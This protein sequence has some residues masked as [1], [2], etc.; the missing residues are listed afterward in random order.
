MSKA[1]KAEPWTPARE[2]ELRKRL[3]TEA[4]GL[5]QMLAAMAAAPDMLAELAR[6]RGVLREIAD[7]VDGPAHGMAADAVRGWRP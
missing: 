6:L 5:G 7:A 1:T 4:P 3:R 2:R